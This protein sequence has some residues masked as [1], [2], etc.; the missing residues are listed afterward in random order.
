MQPNHATNSIGYVPE[1][2][3][4]DRSNNA[5]VWRSMLTL[6][7][8][9]VFGADYPTSPLNVLTQIADA[10][11][12]VSPFGFNNGLPFHPEQALKF[13]EALYAY[14]QA[15]ANITPWKDQIGSVTVGKWADLVLL[16][17]KVPSP[18]N[19]DFRELKVQRTWFAGREVY[20]SEE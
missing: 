4:N 15:G 14:T 5:Y 3:G 16:D 13:E 17:G 2:V 20:K 8:P 1:R 6:G 12:R 11:F 18:M 10:I 7:I 19:E 9:L